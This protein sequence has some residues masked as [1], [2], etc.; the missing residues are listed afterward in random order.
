MTTLGDR[1][2]LISRKSSKQI[3][4]RRLSYDDILDC[5][6]KTWTE[7]EQVAKS[8]ATEAMTI[9]CEAYEKNP[10]FLGSKSKK[11]ILGGLFYLFG[12]RCGHPK[13]QKQIAE[14]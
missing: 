12:Q 13:T 11:W 3:I 10:A 9:I 8:V 14:F 6:L 2:K 5:S 4:S 7:Q 1:E